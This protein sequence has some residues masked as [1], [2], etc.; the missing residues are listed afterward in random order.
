MD[1]SAMMDK[2]RADLRAF[3]DARYGVM[4]KMWARVSDSPQKA[5]YTMVVLMTVAFVLGAV[6]F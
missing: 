4:M 3:D 5:G 1:K 6:V 2:V